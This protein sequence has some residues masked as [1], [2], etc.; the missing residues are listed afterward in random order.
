MLNLFQMKL[1]FSYSNSKHLDIIDV[2][3]VSGCLGDG[4]KLPNDVLTLVGVDILPRQVVL[5]STAPDTVTARGSGDG[6]TDILEPGNLMEVNNKIDL[7]T[8]QVVRCIIYLL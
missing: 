7:S 2:E 4:H 8:I 1:A 6:D 3:K 5:G